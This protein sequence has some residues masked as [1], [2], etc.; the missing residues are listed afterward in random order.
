MSTS[1]TW[2]CPEC[3]HT[4]AISYDWLAEHGGPVCGQCDCDMELQPEAR[5]TADEEVHVVTEL[6]QYPLRIDHAT[7]RRQRQ[8]LLKITDLAQRHQPYT[9]MLGDEALLNGLL[10]LTDAIADQAR[11]QH[12][13]SS[14]RRR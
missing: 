2:Q 12:S 14:R 10:E 1:R 7:F 6:K 8:L 9:P 13:R 4:E 3:G 5:V 11:N